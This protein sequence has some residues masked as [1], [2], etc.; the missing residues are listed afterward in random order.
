M[1][2][3]KDKLKELESDL[4]SGISEKLSDPEVRQEVIDEWNASVNIPLLNEDTEEKI[5]A[6]IYDKAVS[7][8]KK[9]LL[10]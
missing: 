8:L 7:V 5:F 1:S 3:I 10:K 4:K 6:A 2:L 9:V